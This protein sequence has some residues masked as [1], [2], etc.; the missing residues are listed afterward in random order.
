MLGLVAVEAGL[1][2]V[3]EA[4]IDALRRKSVAL[5]ELTVTL[6]DE[7]L[8]AHG[9]SAASP[10]DPSQRGGHVA[11]AHPDAWRI[12]RALIERAA[13]VPDYRAPDAIRLA[14][15]PLY[16]RFVDVWDTVDRL[17]R[18]VVAGEHE[19]LDTALRRVT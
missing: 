2:L 6:A 17:E 16:S 3:E 19:R 5:T 14:Y 9:F 1:E 10:R 12:C 15:P 7:R 11:L 4:G 18:L 13:V 8:S